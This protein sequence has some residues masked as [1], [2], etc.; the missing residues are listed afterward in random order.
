MIYVL[1]G[2]DTKKSYE[3]LRQIL[4]EYKNHLKVTLSKPQPEQ[5]LEQTLALDLTGQEKILTVEGFLAPYKKLPAKF[6]EKIPKESPV[7][8][9]EKT[10]LTPAKVTSLSKI[11]TV[12]LFKETTELFTF[13]DAI[14]Q[15]PKT[16]VAALSTLKGDEGLMYQLQNRLLLMVMSKL[17]VDLV[18]I[19]KITRRTIQSWQWDKIRYQSRNYDLSSLQS[20]YGASLKIDFMVKSGKTSLPN[21]TLITAFLLK[22]FK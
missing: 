17:P 6:F 14:G 11:A 21:K 3:R 20:A 22:Y 13:L 2:D 10:P 8:F 4:N 16:A 1:H 9:W 5:I 7:I 18:T 15:N 19:G 12:E